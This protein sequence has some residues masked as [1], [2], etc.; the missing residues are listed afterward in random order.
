MAIRILLLEDDPNLGL[1]LQEHLQLNGFYVTLCGD[2]EMGSRAFADA[3]YDLCLV[4]IMMPKKDG[5]TFAREVR[6]RNQTI[7]LIFLT[8]KSMKEDKIQGFKI[9]CDD[10]I[11]KRSALRNSC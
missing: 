11:T 5:F 3:E 10:Y 6:Q 4:D 7:P 8:A 2:G 9:G 1:I